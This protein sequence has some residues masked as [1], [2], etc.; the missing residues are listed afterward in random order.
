MKIVI[1][2]NV[3]TVLNLHCCYPGALVLDLRAHRNGY[4]EMLDW[5]PT[6]FWVQT[7]MDEIV[8]RRLLLTIERE[9]I[10]IIGT[11]KRWAEIQVGE[12]Q[13]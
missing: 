11:E 5:E 8:A 6:Y 10:Y 12:S 9:T 1:A 7:P 2:N 4:A 3:E 13:E